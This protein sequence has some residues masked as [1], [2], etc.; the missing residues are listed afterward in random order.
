[1]PRAH[2]I[3]AGDSGLDRYVSTI[4]RTGMLVSAAVILVGGIFFLT[5]HGKA[6]VNFHA[7]HGEPREMTSVRLIAEGALHGEPL[8][9]IQLGLLLLIATPVA[10]VIFAVVAFAWERDYLYVAI[11]LIVLVVLLYSVFGPKGG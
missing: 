4:L 7:F 1:V 6:S 10:R 5:Q 11:S 8:E 3:P 2:A 9:I